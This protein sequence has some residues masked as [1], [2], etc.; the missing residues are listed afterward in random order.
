MAGGAPVMMATLLGLVKEGMT[1][2]TW[3]WT[4]RSMIERR[5]GI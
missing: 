4:P 5:L 1:V 3:P 2:F